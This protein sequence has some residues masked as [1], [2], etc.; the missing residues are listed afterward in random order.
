MTILQAIDI[1][2]VWKPRR[3]PQ[4]TN[5]IRP[6]V[7]PSNHSEPFCCDQ[8]A[9]FFL[10]RNLSHTWIMIQMIETIQNKF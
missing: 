6:R 4:H 1:I 7:L 5:Y 8:T 9:H 10:S 2:K 3:L